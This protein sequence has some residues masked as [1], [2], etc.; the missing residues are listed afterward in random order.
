GQ[1]AARHGKPSRR[2]RGGSPAQAAASPPEAAPPPA[3]TGG[4]SLETLDF[5]TADSADDEFPPDRPDQAASW[6]RPPWETGDR[7]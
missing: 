6:Q 2:Q 1:H 7:S 3:T 5:V 4:V